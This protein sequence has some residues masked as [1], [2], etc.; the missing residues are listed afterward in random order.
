[1]QYTRHSS[2]DMKPQGKKKEFI[3]RETFLKDM[4]SKYVEFIRILIRVSWQYT[5]SYDE[6]E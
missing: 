3:D 6:I 5:L 1:M 2:S 4:V